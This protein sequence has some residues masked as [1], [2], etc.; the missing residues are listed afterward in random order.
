M[1]EATTGTRL[2]AALENTASN[3]LQFIASKNVSLS[4]EAKSVDWRMDAPANG[5]LVRN[6]PVPFFR[7][8]LMKR[9]RDLRT[10]KIGKFRIIVEK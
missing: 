10:V 5:A 3:R 7:E 4:W 9:N 8:V 2:A 6:I 1:F